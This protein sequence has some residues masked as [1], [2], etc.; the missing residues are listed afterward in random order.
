[1]G[2]SMGSTSARRAVWA[3]ALILLQLAPSLLP[4][5]QAARLRRGHG[6]VALPPSGGSVRRPLRQEERLR[7]R[8][9]RTVSAEIGKTRDLRP[10][11]L[12][13]G[14]G[15][16]GED[17]TP[18]TA[19]ELLDSKLDEEIT[20]ASDLLQYETGCEETSPVRYRLADLFWEKSKRY[21]FRANE[22][23][24]SEAGR[25][26]FTQKLKDMQSNTLV[27]YQG[28]LDECPTYT[29]IAKVLFYYG[30]AL[31][32]MERAAEG[33]EIFRR[34]IKDYPGT[35][36]VA[37]SWFMV[38]EYYFN[39][40]NDANQ[41]LKAYI[42]AAE[43]PNS[44]IYG[45]AL[46]KQGW[47]YINV[48]EW[49]LALQR[50][51][52]VVRVSEDKA[53][54]IDD[55]A[56]VSMRKEAL[57]DYVR[58]YAT[59]G[60]PKDAVARFRSVA[61][62]KDLPGMLESLGN[63]YIGQGAHANVVAVYH[64]LIKMYPRSTR[65]P[66]FQGRVVD[67]VSRLGSPKDTVHEVKQLSAYFLQLRVR[68]QKKD[69]TAEEGKT[70][71]RDVREGEEIAENSVRRLATDYH[72]DA[73]KLRGLSQQR[74]YAFALDLYRHYLEVFPEPSPTAEV[75][76]VFF[77]RFYFAEVLFQQEKFLEAATNY[78]RVVEMNP[79]P[80][81]PK[82]KEIVLAAAE[83]SV[84]AYDELVIDLD[85]KKPPEISGNTPK[86]IPEVKEK[87]IASCKRYIDYV[88]IEGDKI[89]EIRY[90]MARIYYT[91]NH[92]DLA[93]PAFNDIVQ[94]HPTNPVACYSAN[95]ALDIYNG[96][97]DYHA[98]KDNARAYSANKK[99][100]C[101]DEDRARF[102]KIE[103]QSTFFLIKSDLEEKKRYTAAGN[104]YM[105]FYH[106]YSTSEFADDAVYNAAVCYDLGQRLDK[107]NEV[108]RYLVE[109]I[110]NSPLVPET[111]YNIAQSYE[112]IVDFDDAAKYL[113][114]FARRYPKD[115]RSKD[116]VF[117]SSLYR[118]T[119][120]D[121]AGARDERLMYIKQYASDAEAHEMAFAMCESVEEEARL[122]EAAYRTDHRRD[123][124]A[125]AKLWSE[126]HDC[127]FAYIR[128]AKYA[129]ADPDGVCHAQFRR[130]EIMR[131]KT[132]Y[133]KG[134]DEQR[135]TL[136]K[137]WPSWKKAHTVA[138]LPRC[139]AAVAE[140]MYR[141]MAFPAKKY[142]D[143]KISEL[144]P[145]DKGK[146][147][148]NASVATKV[149]ERDKLVAD[150]RAVAEMGVAKW[151][152]AALFGIGEAYRESIDA[153]LAAPI[154]DKIPG[155]KLSGEDKGLL[156]QKLRE[157]A[158]PIEET[159]VE[160]YSLC[161]GKANELGVY[162]R[163]SVR[164]L[165]QLQRLRPEAYP[166]VVE[167]TLPIQILTEVEVATNDLVIADGDGFKAVRLR[168]KA[169]AVAV[170]PPPA[171]TPG[172]AAVPASAAP[173]A[174]TTPAAAVPPPLPSVPDGAP[175]PVEE[176][177][178]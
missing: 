122:A 126:A 68:I 101:G 16:S 11:E 51:T 97:K 60:D 98:L 100:A 95:L 141:D 33:A 15:L 36:W 156:R 119:L 149:R 167:S 166:L 165:D 125:V 110:P 50:F 107:A 59:I 169:A 172:A 40:V 28:I 113:V 109:K 177:T 89:V 88:G 83:E 140:L 139:A 55:R 157:M 164:A 118:A 14:P 73:K 43:I 104:A 45:F 168:F 32:E 170:P 105:K 102:A 130:G 67:A 12:P 53:Q 136:L 17:L 18:H 133:D 147:L 132:H 129:A 37:Q 41:A 128:N 26:D 71:E 144:N 82:E 35:E 30:R 66:I 7:P 106:D 34:V 161:V 171:L 151:A 74:Q 49:Q 29:E 70:I 131:L 8:H 46:Y 176:E 20:L 10:V 112:R 143:I 121:F 173:A 80:K 90:K 120:H 19:E 72:R 153:L 134:A 148:F 47:C 174:P 163:W 103:E 135:R 155:Y 154:P 54:P 48:A 31:M 150:Y 61:Q 27:H 162:N 62:P 1:M 175:A 108:R 111:L 93:A 4:R 52:D 115:S 86:A 114:L 158:T 85:R 75:N 24:V 64:A 81:D 152:L 44:P 58:A 138:K 87:L 21:F 160:A 3:T 84:R 159:A 127:Y 76:Y 92:F 142:N 2:V 13:Q 63:W 69:L 77:M 5:A 123:E 99:L 39:T 79:R 96:L 116:A 117:N 42:K 6:T 78:D 145:T 137:M 124:R 22:A 146:K 65:L 23:N 56:R 9:E 94:N 178:P 38:G 91:Y 25:L 57:K